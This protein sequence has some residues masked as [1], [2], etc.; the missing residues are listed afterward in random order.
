M[1]TETARS[2]S[3]TAPSEELASIVPMFMS[4]R[5][6]ELRRS[7]W[8]PVQAPISRTAVTDPK[9]AS[10]PPTDSGGRE[11]AY[12]SVLWRRRLTLIRTDGPRTLS[13]GA[14]AVH[15]RGDS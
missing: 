13:F 5:Q 4:A 2:P 1:R 11:N 7:G 9:F 14:D 6:S 15:S 10:V 3:G 8:P 12:H